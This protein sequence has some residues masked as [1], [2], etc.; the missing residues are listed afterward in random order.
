MSA[1]GI[2][3]I[4]ELA[5]RAGVT[6]KTVRFYSDR[7]L[8]PE[9]GRSAGGHRRYGPEALARLRM[10]R[11]LRTLDLPVPDVGR[12]LDSEDALENAIA[13]Q[14]REL[15]SQLAALRWREAALQLL[16]DCTPEERPERLL[17]VGAMTTPPDTAPMARFWRRWLPARLPARLVSAILER[18]V[19]DPPADPEPADVLAFA[20]MHALVSAPCTG[21]GR[22]QPEVHRPDGDYRPAVLYEGLIEAFALATP[23][24]R[25]RRTPHEGEALDAFVDAHARASGTHDTPAFRRRLSSLLATEPRIDRYW[26]LKAELSGPSAEPTPGAAHDWLHAALDGHSAREAAA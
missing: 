5:E 24:L 17:L 1:D 22:H 19:P 20:R 23:D 11:S 8:L 10:I 12:V 9:A 2:W 21:D 26:Q 18:A 6:V 7:G 16:R 3:S 4:G 15:G 14:L 25:A 13:A